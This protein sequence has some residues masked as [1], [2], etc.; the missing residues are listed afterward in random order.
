M[1]TIIVRFYRQSLLSFKA[2]FGFLDF[3]SYVIVK[4][5]N[6]VLQLIFFTL[7]AKY[8]YN[9]TDVSFWV[10]GNAFLLSVYNSLFG[11]GFVMVDERSF[12]TL[13]SVI[14][15]PA[16]KFLVFIGRAFIHIIDGAA[17]VIV[18]LLIGYLL[19]DVNFAN[20]HFPMFILCILVSMFAA[21]G[22]GLLIG[23]F[24]LIVRDM[25]LIMNLCSFIFLLLCGA[26][27]PISWLPG[28]LQAIS[29]ILPITR[30]IEA[31]RLIVQG[32]ISNYVYE[33]IAFEFII[34]AIYC[35]IGYLLLKVLEN[36][37]RKGASLDIY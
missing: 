32:D 26:Q 28:W 37:A 3:K 2:L 4:I 34:G 8:I 35:I 14:A 19:F 1:D 25:N 20:T 12:G 9:T 7:L 5:I 36:Q 13:K 10:I 27:F 31:S 21:M 15:S 6:P 30:G 29:N 16:N 18:G 22:F 17:S 11:V 24:G 33:L 23:S